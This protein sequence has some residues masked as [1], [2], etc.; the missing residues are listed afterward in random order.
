[1]VGR[2]VGDR[3]GGNVAAAAS[4]RLRYP[5]PVRS[6]RRP[7][8]CPPG[9]RSLDST[10]LSFVPSLATHI[11]YKARALTTF[12]QHEAA[13]QSEVESTTEFDFLKTY[14]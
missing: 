14:A 7:I 6:I 4:S 1:M 13:L 8:A 3:E 5:S 2:G 9:A 11:Q 10:L 12:S